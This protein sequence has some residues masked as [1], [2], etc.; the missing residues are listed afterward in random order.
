MKETI[1][2]ALHPLFRNFVYT[3]RHGL[4]KGLKRKG[5]LGFIPF[6]RPTLEERF[7]LH[8]DLAGQTI[9]DIGGF[10]G[11]F[12]LFF[13]RACGNTGK[14][15][16]FEP[17]PK[18]YENILEIIKL[19]NFGNIEVRKIALGSHATTGTL[20][21][22]HSDMGTASLQEDI[23]ETILR[24]KGTAT[25]QVEVD[26]LDHQIASHS[27][28]GPSFVKIDVEGL[29]MDVLLGMTDTLTRFKPKLF[30]EIHG[31][32]ILRKID[33]VN[34]VVKFLLDR[35][36][37]ILHVESGEMIHY[38][39]AGIAKLGHLYCCPPEQR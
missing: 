28:P 21:V 35:S 19:N 26:S 38:S 27:L 25:I 23:K 30:I 20:A 7:L 13:A 31:V 10:Q 3:A 6:V 1:A 36:Y 12:T 17:N 32:D 22:Q 39:N 2:D 9:Y 37:S 5:G 29:E 14:V 34:T 24:K 4:A 11:I 16:T 15:F 33:N 8:L 18:S